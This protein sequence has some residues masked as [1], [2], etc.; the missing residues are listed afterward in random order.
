MSTYIILIAFA[1]YRLTALT[2]HSDYKIQVQDKKFF[3]GDGD[4]FTF[5]ESRFMIAAAVTAYDGSGEDITDPE[6]GEVKFYMKRF[7][8]VLLQFTE[9][10]I[11]PCKYSTTYGKDFD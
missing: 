1:A 7:G 11:V 9:L 8:D 10:G 2:T 4:E 3:Y 5:E 6:V